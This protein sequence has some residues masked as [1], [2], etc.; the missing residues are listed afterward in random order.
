MIR[1]I[2]LT[3]KFYHSDSI[4]I[5]Y[6]CSLIPSSQLFNVS[7]SNTHILACITLKSWEDLGTRL[8][9]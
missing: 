2:N 8:E 5:L 6:S 7:D 3:D 1:L 4:V 9:N